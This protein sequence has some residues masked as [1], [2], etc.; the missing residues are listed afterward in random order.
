M[1]SPYGLSAE[2]LA[3]HQRSDRFFCA[4]SQA[5][6][7]AFHQIKHPVVFP[8]DA[9]I[10]VEGQSP[11]GVFLLCQG[12]ATSREGKMFIQR[13]AKPGEVLGLNAVVTGKPYEVTVET[14]QPSHLS[15]VNSGDFLRFLKRHGDACLRA[16][17]QTSREC[18]DAYEVVRSIGLSHSVSGRVAKFLLKSAAEGRI[19]NGAVHVRLV[20]THEDISQ[21][22]GTSRETITRTLSEFRKREIVELKGSTLIIH[23]RPA[24]EQLVAA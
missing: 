9:V 10:F 11:R 7:N 2:C 16:A 24:L 8:E 6:I 5:S 4:L 17:Q 18:Q 3:C 1:N 21:L 23:N 12:Q 13:I 15:F 19:S 22:I 20:L 14:M